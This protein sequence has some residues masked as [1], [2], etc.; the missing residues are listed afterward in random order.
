MHL[1]RHRDIE[2]FVTKDGSEIREWAG[3]RSAPAVNQSLAEA[4]IAPGASTQ[5][6]YH[7]RTEELYLVLGG[8]G[9]LRVG[10]DERDVVEGD[11]ALIPPG[12]EHR[13][14]NTGREP[15]R[16]LCACAPAYADEDTVLTG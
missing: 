6:H 13:L 16:I 4:T 1:T 12:A 3:P 11:C 2:P 14:V 9:R 5:A 15:L 8:T 10:D 7:R